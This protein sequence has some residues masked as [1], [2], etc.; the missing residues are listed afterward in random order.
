MKKSTWRKFLAGFMIAIGLV[1]MIKT[2]VKLGNASF[3]SY[4]FGLALLI[5][6]LFISGIFPR[7]RDKDKK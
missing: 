6:G 5:L 4:G 1:I 2:L 3:G 7:K